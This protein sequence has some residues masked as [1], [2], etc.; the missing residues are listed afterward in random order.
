MEWLNDAKACLNVA[1]EMLVEAQELQE[2]ALEN[3]IYIPYFKVKIKNF[4]ENCRSPLDYSAQYVFD[5]YCKVEYTGKERK[6][7][8]PYFPIRATRKEFNELIASDF[9]KLLEKKCEI[10]KMW[11]NVQSFNSSEWLRDLNRLLN[12][13]KHRHLTKQNKL[14]T[15]HVPHLQ[16][17]T[18]TFV[19]SI[20]KNTGTDIVVNG[21]P[22]NFGDPNFPD[23]IRYFGE[24]TNT[25]FIFSDLD[26]SII[27]TLQ[28]ILDGAISVIDAM[29]ENS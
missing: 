21:Q 13:N 19:N 23:S 22:F 8:K 2:Q 11:E 3:E 12:K 24:T 6:S 15:T 26:K 10:V 7:K 20:F 14:R 28:Q 9:R 4:L 27:P 18:N 25:E 29:G 16:I 5:T 17:G 1:R